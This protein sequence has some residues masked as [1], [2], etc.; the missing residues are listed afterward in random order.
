MAEAF[1]YGE[2]GRLYCEGVA[3][4]E[5]AEAVSTPLYVYGGATMRQRYRRLAAALDAAFGPGRVNLAYALKA[6]PNQAVI[7]L[8]AREGAGADVVS[9]GELTRAL[10]AGIPAERIVLAGVGKTAAEID[11]ALAA[12]IQQF[13]V[14]SE[15][16]LELIAAR[17]EAAGT[18]APV[19]VRVNPNV[20]ARTHAKIATGKAETKFGVDIEAVPALMHRAQ[21]SD[22]LAV[23]GL[24]MHIGSQLTQLAPFKEAALALGDLAQRL[25]HEGVPVAHLDLGG[26]L[27]VV[28][29]DETP[30]DPEAYARTL[31]ETLGHLD[32]AFTLEPGRWL[33]AEAGGLLTRVLYS[34]AGYA[35]RFIVVDGA[36]ND[37]IRPTLYDA[38][39][40]IDPVSAPGD[41]PIAEADVV[42][43]V[44]ETG[45][46]FGKGRSLPELAGGELLLVGG[47]GA[48]GAAMASNYDTRPSAGEVLVDG[49][50]YAVVR[51]QRR[52]AEVILED[53]VPDWLEG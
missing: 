37:F 14:E 5:L 11:T 49:G 1:T 29:G 43:P 38:W 46:F 20:D 34:K 47:A 23:R 9:G 26:G 40:R 3:L 41:R 22:W 17:A 36:M 13:N 19:A 33:T 35:R 44:C 48:Y 12:G 52:V 24:A 4:A 53:T 28:Y 15:A 27:G 6:N 51:R 8:F 18:P 7:S 32:V 16:E 31:A 2:D 42:G 45:D 21:A 30:P 50:R 39:H 10:W 25:Q